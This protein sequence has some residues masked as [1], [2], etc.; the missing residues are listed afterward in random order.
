MKIFLKVD[1]FVQMV[2]FSLF[3]VGI[4]LTHKGGFII[5]LYAY[6]FIGAWQLICGVIHAIGNS[7]KDTIKYLQ[8][9]VLYLCGL[10]FIAEF[11]ENYTLTYLY[12]GG[13]IIIAIWNLIITHRAYEKQNIVRSF[14]DLEI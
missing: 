10:M 12:L 6:F 14:W 3:T 1:Y 13:S 2:L 11:I 4:L 5:S 7:S 9:A 8:V